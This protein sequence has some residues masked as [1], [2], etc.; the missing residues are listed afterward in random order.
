VAGDI[1]LQ[2]ALHVELEVELA[3]RR[4]HVPAAIVLG[5]SEVEFI[6]SIGLATLLSAQ[7]RAKTMGCRMRVSAASPLLA[8][9]IDMS[10][11][12]GGV[13]YTDHA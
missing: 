13:K 1:D 5:L 10:G 12:T 7:R 11:L 9:L 6:D 4:D 2:T 8:R 3:L